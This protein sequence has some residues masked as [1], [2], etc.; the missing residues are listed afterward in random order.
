MDLTTF[1]FSKDTEFGCEFN[2]FKRQNTNE[3]YGQQNATHQ[4]WNNNR[5]SRPNENSTHQHRNEYNNSHQGPD[6]DSDSGYTHQNY[7]GAS[8][9]QNHEYRCGQQDRYGHNFGPDKDSS[10]KPTNKQ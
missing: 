3:G 10:T 8:Y 2:I 7:P 1:S 5:Q 9:Q 6:S 4:Q